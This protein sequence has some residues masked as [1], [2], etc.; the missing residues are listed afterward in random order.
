M[1]VPLENFHFS[2]DVLVALPNLLEFYLFIIFLIEEHESILEAALP[3]EGQ[4]WWII[5]LSTDA[6]KLNQLAYSIYSFK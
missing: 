5:S 1:T 4:K 6:Q 2:G 3:K